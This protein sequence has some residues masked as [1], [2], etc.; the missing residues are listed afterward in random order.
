MEDAYENVVVRNELASILNE[1]QRNSL[2]HKIGITSGLQLFQNNSTE[3]FETEFINLMNRVLVVGIKAPHV[4][5]IIK[6]MS[7]LLGRIHEE[8]T[9]NKD[10]TEEFL[11]SQTTRKKKNN[12][13]LNILE[14]LMDITQAKDK[15]VRW[16]TCQ[17][18][19]GILNT[20]PGTVK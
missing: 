13:V 20:I 8:I 11:S 14:Y 6:F 2:S 5:R 16:R 19:G 1:A 15:A 12:I 4:E 3:I 17:L 7:T 10:N 18:I 9:G